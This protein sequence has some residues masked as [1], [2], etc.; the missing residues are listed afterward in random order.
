MHTA[1][2]PSTNSEAEH[3]K[4]CETSRSNKINTTQPDSS[5]TFTSTLNLGITAS[6]KQPHFSQKKPSPSGTTFFLH[7]L[8][9]L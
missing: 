2:N 8:H 7:F 3:I 9:E 6:A 1:T 5:T 4:T